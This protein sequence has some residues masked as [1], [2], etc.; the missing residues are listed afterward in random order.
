[1]SALRGMG[2]DGCRDARGDGVIEIGIGLEID[3]RHLLLALRDDAQLPR[4][5]S[6]V[7]GHQVGGVDA[8]GAEALPQLPG[9][10]VVTHHADQGNR[11]PERRK[12]H[13]HIGGP[14]GTVVVVVVLDDRDGRLGRQPLDTAEQEVVEHHV[15]DDD[16]AATLE[17]AGS[18]SVHV[19][20][21]GRGSR[22]VRW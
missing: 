6:R 3:P 15:A 4:R 2:G 1:M 22:R 19:R 8:A 11:R 14:A 16:H 17:A 7:V 20:D 18:A 9:C 13:G 12:V 5:R 21:R 10:L